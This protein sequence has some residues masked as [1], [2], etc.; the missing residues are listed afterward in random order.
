MLVM[1]HISWEEERA[2]NV[3]VFSVMND[4]KSCF[5]AEGWTSW[6]P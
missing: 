3:A 2:L 6:I 1:G 4:D 5:K